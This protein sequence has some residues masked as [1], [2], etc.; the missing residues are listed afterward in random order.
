MSN[1][2]NTETAA[3]IRFNVAVVQKANDAINDNPFLKSRMIP[4][5]ANTWL[6]RTGI[7]RENEEGC[8][9]L[10]SLIDHLTSWGIKRTEYEFD[11]AY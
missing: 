6:I 3:K 4:E 8:D 5:Y 7:I 2:D 1:T 9:F 10:E 11:E